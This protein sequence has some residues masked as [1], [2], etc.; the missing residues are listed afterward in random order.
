MQT[1]G[2]QELGL[3]A[4]YL[5]FP[6][7]KERLGDLLTAFSEIGLQGFNVTVPFKSDIIPHLDEV[8]PAALALGSVN[9]VI[10]TKTGWKGYSTDGA[11]YVR[12]LQEKDFA[13]E[14]KTVALLGAGGSAKAVAY[15]LA[16]A[17]IESLDIINRTKVNAEELKSLLAQHFP[18]LKITTEQSHDNYDLL[19]NTTSFG[20]KA[21]DC[22]AS[23]ALIASAGFVSDIIYNPKETELLK[24]AAA[25]GK[26][27]QNG[28][29]MLLFQGVLAFEIWT[30]KPAPVTVMQK[31]LQ[32]HMS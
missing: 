17:G 18:K 20:M 1:S 2:F 8:D 16:E 13:P 25:L 30:D 19:L 9:T 24:Q 4:V 6:T 21:G 26:P 28:L 32:N 7:K 15:A 14:G 31:V 27:T 29:S 10:R 12:G 5:P 3:N 11:G 23:Q 22:P